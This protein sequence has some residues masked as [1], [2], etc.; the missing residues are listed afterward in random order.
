MAGQS[1]NWDQLRSGDTAPLPLAVETNYTPA[2][3]QVVLT[4]VVDVT[5]GGYETVTIATYT[6]NYEQRS[7]G[8]EPDISPA[9]AAEATKAGLRN[10]ALRLRRALDQT[11]TQTAQ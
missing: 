4:M 2:G 9:A 3:W 6:Q 1:I 11:G 5:A 8:Q 10:F 7:D